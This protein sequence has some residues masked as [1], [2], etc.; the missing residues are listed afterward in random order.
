MRVKDKGNII[1]NILCT[2]TELFM[3]GSGIAAF[4][5]SEEQ[6][7]VFIS[8]FGVA[9]MMFGLAHIGIGWLQR[10]S[11]NTKD[12][13]IEGLFITFLSLPLLFNR[14]HTI[15]PLAIIVVIWE[16]FS[17]VL[18]LTE[19]SDMKQKKSGFWIAFLVLAIVEILSSISAIITI[20]PTTKSANELI[21]SIFLLQFG[22]LGLKM[23]VFFKGT[24]KNK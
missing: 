16:L 19:A 18:K 9:M 24:N 1:V 20:A 15:Y 3:L 13:Y 2:I 10:R 4:V 6:M 14:I 8:L 22:G 17:G 5:T 23:V 21:A 7:V 11:E 12:N